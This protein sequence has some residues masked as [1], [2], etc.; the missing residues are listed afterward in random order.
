MT[1]AKETIVFEGTVTRDKSRVLSKSNGKEYVLYTVTFEHN[2]KEY[3]VPGSFTLDADKTMPS[4]GDKVLVYPS[5]A[6][7]DGVKKPFFDIAVGA[8]QS[9]DDDLLDLL[10]E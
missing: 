3:T 6:E 1:N 2:G 10:G 8:L 9:S 7:K 5:V 4:L